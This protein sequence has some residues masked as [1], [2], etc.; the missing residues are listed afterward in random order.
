MQ[1][2]QSQT[3]WLCSSARTNRE[4][5][6]IWLKSVAQNNGN[7]SCAGKEPMEFEGIKKRNTMFSGQ[8]PEEDISLSRTIQFLTIGGEG[9]KSMLPK[10]GT[11]RDGGTYGNTSLFLS[12]GWWISLSPVCGAYCFARPVNGYVADL[13]NSFRQ[14]GSSILST[15]VLY[16]TAE[17]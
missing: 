9:K 3:L 7:A 4:L 11:R 12:R 2:E 14:T 10:F 15:W 6:R 1:S 13:G 5:G 16:F 17:D 8:R